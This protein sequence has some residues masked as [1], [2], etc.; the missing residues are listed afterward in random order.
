MGAV[1]AVERAAMGVFR[2]Q[3]VKPDADDPFAARSFADFFLALGFL[4]KYKPYGVK[5]ASPFGYSLFDLHPGQGFSFQLHLEPK[6]EAF[7][8]LHAHPGG[9]IY[10]SS[11]PE[12][13]ESGEKDAVVWSE[14]DAEIRSSHTWS[15]RPGDIAR[16]TST[17]IVHTVVGCTLE[18]YATTSFDAVERLLD[19]NDRAGLELPARHPEIRAMLQNLHPDLPRRSLGRAGSGWIRADLPPSEPIID[20]PGQLL[21]R[22]LRIGPGAD[23]RLPAPVGWV[24]VVVPTSTAVRCA[25]ADREWTVSPGQIFT[26]PPG[27]DAEV[28]ADEPTVVSIQS[29]A[30]ELILREWAG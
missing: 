18:E 16:I 28:T 14:G 27:W 1:E 2:Q 11:H 13:L 7:H 25:F 22:R 6:Y 8:I 20:V 17:E 30:P 4:Y 3:L 10:L 26:V 23:P 19:Q 9:F 21:G 29:I 12:W 15:P 24:K 5:A